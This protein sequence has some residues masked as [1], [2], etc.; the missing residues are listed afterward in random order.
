MLILFEGH[1]AQIGHAK[2]FMESRADGRVLSAEG[3]DVPCTEAS[4]RS[5]VA[6]T[7]AGNWEA[8][9]V[10]FAAIDSWLDVDTP[11]AGHADDKPD[12]SSVGTITWRVLAGGGRFAGATGYVTGNFTG[13]PDGSF[14]DHQLFKL[15]VPA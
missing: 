14:I 7:S 15:F 4:F 6:V 1:G 12:G 5:V 13:A 9:R 2:G 10:D 3:L 8:G 11:F